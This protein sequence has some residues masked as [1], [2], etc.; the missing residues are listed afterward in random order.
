MKVNDELCTLVYEL[1]DMLNFPEKF[2]DEIKE[3]HSIARHFIKTGSKQLL[4]IDSGVCPECGERTLRHHKEYDP[5]LDI[6]Y[7]YVVCESC[8]IELEY[9]ELKEMSKIFKIG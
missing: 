2:H 9:D 8:E 5:F 4:K 1:I 6:K 3:R 7:H